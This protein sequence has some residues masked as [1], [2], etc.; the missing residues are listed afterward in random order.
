MEGIFPAATRVPPPRS[1]RDSDDGTFFQRTGNHVPKQGAIMKWH[2]SSILLTLGILGVAAL[3]IPGSLR[4]Q[5]PAGP[6]PA[7]QPQASSSAPTP[8]NQPRAETRTS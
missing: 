1:H 5:A 8:Q 2:N 7:A 4:A 3:A 6:L